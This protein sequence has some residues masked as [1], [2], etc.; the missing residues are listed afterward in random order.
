MAAGNLF[1]FLN[2]FP[3]RHVSLELATTRAS[4]CHDFFEN[5]AGSPVKTSDQRPFTPAK[6]NKLVADG[7]LYY[8]KA[9]ERDA[10]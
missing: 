4:Y 3:F 10:R 1:E 8:D 7:I 2:R 9:Q 5:G 6:R